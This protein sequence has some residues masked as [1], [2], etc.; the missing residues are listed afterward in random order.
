[1]L[2]HAPRAPQTSSLQGIFATQQYHPFSSALSRPPPHI[3]ALTLPN[4]VRGL[5]ARAQG[6]SLRHRARPVLCRAR[7]AGAVD[8]RLWACLPLVARR[9]ACTLPHH[10][11]A[12]PML[13]C[14]RHP[15][16]EEQ[17][18]T[19]WT[20]KVMQ[21]KVIKAGH[22]YSTA[23]AVH[24]AAGKCPTRAHAHTSAPPTLPRT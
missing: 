11:R 17:T 21:L 5:T 15:H 23:M 18:S 22:S 14:R 20:Q 2:Q 24:S 10:M 6:A 12:A 1:M 3:M 4:S 9:S 13:K 8:R 19:N 16:E 7:W